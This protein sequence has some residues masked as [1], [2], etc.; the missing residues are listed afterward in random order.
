MKQVILFL[1][2]F[3]SLLPGG[4]QAGEK[5]KEAQPAESITL[6]QPALD[7][8]LS[9]EKALLSRRSVRDFNDQALTLSQLSQLLWAAQGITDPQG[10]RTAP[11]AGALYPLE[12]YVVAGKVEG[13]PAGVYKYRPRGH[14]VVRVLSGD[15]RKEVARAALDQEALKQGAVV[16]LFSGVYERT[17]WKYAER[18]ERYVAIEVGHA[19]QNVLL[20][21]TALGL[22]AVPMGAFQDEEI[23]KVAALLEDERPLLLVPVGVPS[24]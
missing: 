21:A 16:L 14:Q 2:V 24:R 4:C 10:F 5:G 23:K 12:V 11:S 8:K 20:Q 13:L 17:S 6:P 3:L 19:A 22:G 18:A 1:L 7:G 15:R 9:L